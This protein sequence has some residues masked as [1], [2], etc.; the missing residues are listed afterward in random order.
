MG[1]NLDAVC[2]SKGESKEKAEGRARTSPTSITTS[3]AL[4][5]DKE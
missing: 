2:E 5:T 3:G 1:T 4:G